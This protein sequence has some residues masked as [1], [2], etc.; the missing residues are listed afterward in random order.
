MNRINTHIAYRDMLAHSP[1]TDV[2]TMERLARWEHVLFDGI[3]ASM[4]KGECSGIVKDFSLRKLWRWERIDAGD[5]VSVDIE[6]ED[7]AD[8]AFSAD[9]VIPWEELVYSPAHD[10]VICLSDWEERIL[11]ALRRG[12]CSGQLED[13][14]GTVWRWRKA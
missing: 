10:N 14:F 2:Q 1:R 9:A 5:I 13:V 11:F 7:D 6:N 8:A 4:V 3:A 12:E